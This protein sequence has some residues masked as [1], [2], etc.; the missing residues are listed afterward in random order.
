MRIVRDLRG[1]AIRL[2]P[3]SCQAGVFRGTRRVG[4]LDHFALD[5]PL[6]FTRRPFFMQFASASPTSTSPTFPNAQSPSSLLPVP[7][8]N[9]PMASP[10]PDPHPCDSLDPYADRPPTSLPVAISDHLQRSH[11]YPSAPMRT[12]LANHKQVTGW[13]RSHRPFPMLV[14]AR[15]WSFSTILHLSHPARKEK[16]VLM[17]IC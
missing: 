3:R 13:V 2:A 16:F 10:I 14:T 1:R 6:D 9:P 7:F 5:V 8:V 15:P 11:I 4:S 17:K 12:D